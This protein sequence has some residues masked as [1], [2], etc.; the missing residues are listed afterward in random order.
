MGYR[1]GCRQAWG[2]RAAG[3]LRKSSVAILGNGLVPGATEL[4]QRAGGS[5]LLPKE[6]Q[7]APW[8]PGHVSGTG[9]DLRFSLESFIHPPYFR[10]SWAPP[11]QC[12]G[13]L[14]S[15]RRRAPL[16]HRQMRDLLFLKYQDG[17]SV[18]SALLKSLVPIL[19]ITIPSPYVPSTLSSPILDISSC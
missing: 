11:A 4:L 5:W 1:T 9:S 18:A 17:P 7:F 14:A 2:Q 13:E 10:S 6:Q 12:C 8:Y 3:R 15:P 19:F 16:P